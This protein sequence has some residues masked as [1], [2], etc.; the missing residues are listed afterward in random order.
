MPTRDRVVT[1]PEPC[2]QCGKP[3]EQTM[4]TWTTPSGQ[5]LKES[6]VTTECTGDCLGSV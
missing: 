4:R 2:K 3:V 5:F 6:A 1:R